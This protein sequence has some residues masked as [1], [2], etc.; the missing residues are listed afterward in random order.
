MFNYYTLV[1]ILQGYCL[2]HAFRNQSAY[3]WY[4]II[5]F[6]PVVGSIVYLYIHFGTKVDIDHVGESFKS[7]I[8]SD[9]EVEKLLRESKFSDTIANRIRLADTYAAKQKYPQAIALY[10]SCLEGYNEDDTLTTEKLMVAKYFSQDY[11][12]VRMLGDKMNDNPAFRNSESRIG[13]AWS[14]SHLGESDKAEKVFQAMNSRFSNY[15]HRYEYAKFLIEED[16]KIDARA[17]LADLED[18]IEHMGKAEQR[19]KRDIRKE[20]NT[21]YKSIR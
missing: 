7:A 9:Y 14:L 19:Q 10:E 12:G 5:L 15:V 4:L 13:Y 6:L 3:Y 17:L 21:L 20:I 18:E 16:R 2:F 1:L 11:H 8:N